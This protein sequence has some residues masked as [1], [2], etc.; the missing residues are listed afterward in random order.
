LGVY[1]DNHILGNTDPEAVALETYLQNGGKIYL[2]GG[3]CFNYDPENGGYNIRPWFGLND[4]PDG[5]GDVDAVTGINGLAAF[6]FTYEGPNNWMDELQP[7]TSVPVWENSNNP[8][9]LGVYNESFGNG[10]AIGVVPAFG[11]MQNSTLAA[12]ERPRAVSGSNRFK[13]PRVVDETPRPFVKKYAHHPE[14]AGKIDG[15]QYLAF[16]SAGKV[17]INAN[18][19][20]ELMA[21]YLQLLNAPVTGIDDD[22]TNAPAAF[23][24]T[25]NYPNPFNPMTTFAVTLPQSDVASVVVYNALGQVVARLHD[26]KLSA[27]KHSFTFDAAGFASGLYF[28]RVTTTQFTK[29]RKMMLIK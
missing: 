14:L 28:Y 15:R 25:Q 5:T 21:A 1:S 27:G 10:L 19:K 16:D 20:I 4:G 24:L 23:E 22:H 7:A 29:T 11:G 13:T 6:S 8:D 2:E 18:N 26:G 17:V 9:V 12:G 3:D